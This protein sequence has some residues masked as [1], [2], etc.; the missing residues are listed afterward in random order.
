MQCKKQLQAFRR[1]K[2]DTELVANIQKGIVDKIIDLLLQMIISGVIK[3]S[4][5]GLRQQIDLIHH[6]LLLNAVS[7]K[8]AC[9]YLR[10][11]LI[12]SGIRHILLHML[13]NEM[14]FSDSAQC[15]CDMRSNILNGLFIDLIM[16]FEKHISHY[17][18]YIRYIFG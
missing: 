13:F 1:L 4:Q 17:I 8:K 2:V 14:T 7:G 9:Q 16:V 10:G 5:N 15:E 18:V 3:L 11:N 12:F 6:V